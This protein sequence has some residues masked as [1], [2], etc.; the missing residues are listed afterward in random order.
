MNTK[1]L[2]ARLAAQCDIYR[3][4]VDSGDPFA[5]MARDRLDE[6]ASEYLPSGSG[7]DS[8]CYVELDESRADKVVI[9]CDFHHMN[10]TG[11]Y[12]GW[13]THRAI[14]TPCL[15]SGYA[16]RITG[17]D[18]N[19]IKEYIGDTMADALEQGIEK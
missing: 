7:F 3:R 19:G 8:G 11:H 9:R 15:I 4:N 6:L 2:Y 12:D 13:T 17:K 18:K 5:D 14:V 10:E 16:L 1:P